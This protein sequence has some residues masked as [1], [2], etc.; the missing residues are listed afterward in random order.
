MKKFDTEGME[1]LKAEAAYV[2]EYEIGSSP[3]FLWE[4]K[5]VLDYNELAKKPGLG[6]FNRSSSNSAAAAPAGSC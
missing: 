3:S 6:F 1:L 2:D 5:E 4:G